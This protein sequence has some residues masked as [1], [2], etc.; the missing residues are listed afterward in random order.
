MIGEQYDF[1]AED[2][3]EVLRHNGL[4]GFEDIWNLPHVWVQRPNTRH[5]GFAGVARHEFTL[6]DGSRRGYYVKIHR[7]RLRR[8]AR[9]PW[10]G[11]PVLQHELRN[12]RSCAIAGV[13]SPRPV[14]CAN[15]MVEGQHRG[16]FVTEEVTTHQPLAS[17]IAAWELKGR[18]PTIERWWVIDAVAAQLRALHDARLRV[19]AYTPEHIFVRVEHGDGSVAGEANV[20]VRLLDLERIRV[21]VLPRRTQVADLVTLHL[22]TPELHWNERLRFLISYLGVDQLT[23]AVKHLWYRV[24]RAA[25]AKQR[26]RSEGRHRGFRG[27]RI[28]LGLRKPD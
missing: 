2:W 24:A 14:Y 22:A 23:P 5:H 4:R 16:I 13:G 25:E 28:R 11:T 3:R 26:R 21:S 10:L 9:R 17:V 19:A 15:R 6:P 18:P 1:E 8:T 27:L 20:S 7:N 12:H